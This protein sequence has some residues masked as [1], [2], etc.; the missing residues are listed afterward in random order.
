MTQDELS[1]KY[2]NWMYQLVCNNEYNKRLSHRKLLYFLHDVEFTYSIMMDENRAIDGVDLRYRFGYECGYNKSVIAEYLDNGP[3][4]VLEMM[5]ALSIRCEESIMDDPDIGNRTGKWFWDMV[6]NLGLSAMIDS[7]FDKE[8]CEFVI[9]RFLTRKYKRNGE[10][11]L[12]TIYDTN[13]DL[14]DVEIWYQM[15][16][17]LNNILEN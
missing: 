7:K 17:H 2:F 1:N 6:T 16:W 4:S 12:F 5:I 11:G 15:C 10:G 13:R 3:C 8:Y 9:E 14:R